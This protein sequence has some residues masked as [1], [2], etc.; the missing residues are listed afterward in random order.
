MIRR[1][2]V[3]ENQDDRLRKRGIGDSINTFYGDVTDV[4]T[5]N[6]AI[7]RIMPD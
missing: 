3:A 4:S 1:N 6:N 5:I 7:S 2:S